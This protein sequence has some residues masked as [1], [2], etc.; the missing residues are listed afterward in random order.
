MKKASVLTHPLSLAF[1]ADR[2][3]T[4][5]VQP[6]WAFRLMSGAKG[7]RTHIVVEQ[8]GTWA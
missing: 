7:Q 4:P 8:A 6:S 1:N 5:W 2:S 3:Q